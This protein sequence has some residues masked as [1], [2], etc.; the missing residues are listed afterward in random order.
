LT[1]NGHH[2]NENRQPQ[3]DL[4]PVY[5]G[6][7]MEYTIAYLI[8]DRLADAEPVAALEYSWDALD[9]PIPRRY[10]P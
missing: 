7:Q 1:Q 3:P 10:G 5:G 9:A 6:D 4:D 8:E 2:T